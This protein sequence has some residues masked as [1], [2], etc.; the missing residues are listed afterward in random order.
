MMPDDIG[1]AFVGIV[2]II[3]IAALFY[4]GT[5]RSRR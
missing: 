5:P 4:S 3:I 1:E 2:V